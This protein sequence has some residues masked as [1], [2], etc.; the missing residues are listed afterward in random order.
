MVKKPETTADS[1]AAD[2]LKEAER[3]GLMSPAGISETAIPSLGELHQRLMVLERAM[4]DRVTHVAGLPVGDV[5]EQA[6]HLVNWLFDHGSNRHVDKQSIID[7]GR[8]T[9]E[10]LLKQEK[11]KAE[12]A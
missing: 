1:V 12:N 9:M 10:N 11:E 3:A 8:E 6:Y 4:G 5:V 7:Q 2:A